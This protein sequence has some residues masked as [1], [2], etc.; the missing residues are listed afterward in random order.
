MGSNKAIEAGS[1]Q[2]RLNILLTHNSGSFNSIGETPEWEEIELGVDSGATETVVG[3]DML[4]GIER[5]DGEQKRKGVEYEIATGELIPNL[6]EKKMLVVSEEEV[7]RQLTAQVAD[8]NQALLSVC[9][10]MSTGHRVVFDS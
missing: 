5:Q 2:G 1:V 3:P 7:S 4:P 10:M 8:V 6:G 9:R